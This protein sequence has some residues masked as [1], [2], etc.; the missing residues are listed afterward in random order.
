MDTMRLVRPA[1]A[2]HGTRLTSHLDDQLKK[3]MSETSVVGVY[4]LTTSIPSVSNPL[5]KR[6][7]KST[8]HVT[9]LF[10]YK[11]RRTH[12]HTLNDQEPTVLSG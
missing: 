3:P 7:S 10:Q 4:C 1:A 8:E 12:W 6:H 11:K 5:H 9:S 2:A